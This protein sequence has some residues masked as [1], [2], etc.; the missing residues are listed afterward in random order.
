MYVGPADSRLADAD[1]HLAPARLRHLHACLLYTSS[2]TASSDAV[3]SV[4][5]SSA[6]V[7]SDTVSSDTTSPEAASS[8]AVSSTAV[9]YTHLPRSSIWRTLRPTP[10]MKRA[11]PSATR[12]R[13]SNAS[14]WKFPERSSSPTRW[15][16]AAPPSSP[17][18]R[19][20]STPPRTHPA[21]P[22]RLDA[23]A[24]AG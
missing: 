5:A 3:S 22:E 12:T 24:E 8:V 19:P 10:L 15:W 2:T 13:R 16:T 20:I 17:P 14:A 21:I 4:P 9:S 18:K 23:S 1:Q 6:V 11:S 7:S